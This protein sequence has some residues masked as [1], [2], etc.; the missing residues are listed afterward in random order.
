MKLQMLLFACAVC[1]LA[2]GQQP[3]SGF[4]LNSA[5][6]Y[7]YL[8][9]DHVGPRKPLRDGES[10]IGLWLRI[11]NNCRAPISVPTFGLTSGDAGVGV[12]DEVVPD[13]MNAVV[14]NSGA[15]DLSEGS[16][17]S[18]API[19]PPRGYS[20][21][22]FSTTRVL[23]GKDLL[24]SVPINH[25]GDQWFMRVR[26]VLDV[27]KPSVGTGPYTYLEFSKTEL[28]PGVTKNSGRGDAGPLP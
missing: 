25:V 3:I 7:V 2:Q 15:I 24:F 11:V 9:F 22:V 14:I 28:P 16:A 1:A 20:A 27:N 4:V 12:F 5:K 8:Q 21:E 26:F 6:P 18:S 17:S 19:H 10:N 23:P 13:V